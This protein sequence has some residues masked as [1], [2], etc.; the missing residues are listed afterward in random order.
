MTLPDGPFPQ[1]KRLAFRLPTKEDAPFYREMMNEPDY[2]RFIADRGIRTDADA[3][4]YIEN[5]TLAHFEKH[6]VGLW[7]VE[8]KQTGEPLGACGLVVR[9]DLDYPDLGYA[10]CEKNRGQGYALEAG[11]AVLDFVRLNTSLDR[12]C[13]IT[14]LENARSARLLLK[15]GFVAEGRKYLATYDDMSDYFLFHF[16]RSD[17]SNR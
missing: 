8:H 7:L 5:K 1:S 6:K 17:Q 4:G 14:H 2:H 11:Q 9:D 12:L 3:A 15:L 10:F 16:N 13:A